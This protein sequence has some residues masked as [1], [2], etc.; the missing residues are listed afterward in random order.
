MTA[1][2]TVLL[3]SVFSLLVSTGMAWVARKMLLRWPHKT[4]DVGTALT[5]GVT[6]LVFGPAYLCFGWAPGLGALLMS[7][8]GMGIGMLLPRQPG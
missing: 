6:T 2:S 1:W 7:L 3:V 8:V 4:A 5:L